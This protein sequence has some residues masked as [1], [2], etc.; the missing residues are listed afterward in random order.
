MALLGMDNSQ[1][2]L[3]AITVGI[4]YTPA[5]LIT[6]VAEQRQ[7]PSGK[8]DNRLNLDINWRYRGALR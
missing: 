7:G 3:H 5:P 2:N 1:K 8:S 6:L 4:Y